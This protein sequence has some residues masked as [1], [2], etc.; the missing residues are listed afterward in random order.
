MFGHWKVCWGPARVYLSTL[1]GRCGA[2][3]TYLGAFLALECVLGRGGGL[4]WNQGA[5]DVRGCEGGGWESALD[6]GEYAGRMPS[7]AIYKV[8]ASRVA[9]RGGIGGPPGG[10]IGRAGGLGMSGRS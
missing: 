3:R 7:D 2:V 9:D 8:F 6:R 4:R 5:G 10:G 1:F